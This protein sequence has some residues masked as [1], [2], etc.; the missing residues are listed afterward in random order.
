MHIRAGFRAVV[1]HPALILGE[2]AWR[3]AFGVAAWTLIIIAV[4]RIFARVD[5][6]Q[7]E[8]LIARHSD[9]FLVA[10][11]CARILAQVLP[12]FARECLVLLPAIAV[13]WIAA[14]TLG[15]AVTLQA[16]VSENQVV[17]PGAP[18]GAGSYL[19][20]LPK[21]AGASGLACIGAVLAKDDETAAASALRAAWE[22]A[23]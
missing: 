22:S 20:G 10:D 2:I 19:S 18:A 17:G 1:R 14:A 11:A 23:A 9:V 4:H 21:T 8:L 5:I 15:R 7:P 12:Q 6:T 3:W 16:L 13:L